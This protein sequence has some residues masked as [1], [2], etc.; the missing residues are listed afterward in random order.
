[1]LEKARSFFNKTID[2]IIPI[3]ATILA[4]FIGIFVLK[5]L[6][7][8][9]VEAYKALFEGAFGSQRAIIQTTIKA[10]P[11]LLVG[12]GVCIAF[13]GGVINI[14]GEGQI[15]MGALASAAV[16]LYLPIKSRAVMIP[17]CLLSSMLAGAIWGG[18]PGV[19]KARIGVNEILTTVMMNSIAVYFSN[20]LLRG[21]MIDP[22]EIEMGTRAAQTAL[23][24]EYTWLTRLAPPTQLNTGTILAVILSVLAF[25][26][27]WRTTIG[28]R[29][30]AV[31]FNSDASRYAGI[32]VP[33]YQALALILSGAFAGLAGGIEVFGVQHR[34]LE[35]I[36]AN[37]GFNGI[38]TAL[39][40]N[41]HPIGTIPAAFLFGGLMVGGNKM[42]RT[43]QV[44]SAFIDTMLGLVVLFVV[45]AKIFSTN[46]S[47][48]RAKNG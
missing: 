39:F 40:G 41:L 34:V 38:V 1:M 26:L 36:S 12:I 21:P 8:D 17:V 48:R 47:K 24:P 42:Q 13:R 27:L 16:A 18:I 45:G 25:I 29:I 44:H 31:G 43:V 32:R 46:R 7:K 14:G 20:F 10:T 37:Y 19:L 30:R 2:A 3:F 23:M 4:L 5:A 6:G 22:H 35:N 9:P 11:L 33:V 15:I 28:Y